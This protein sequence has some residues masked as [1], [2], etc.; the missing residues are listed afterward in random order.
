MPNYDFDCTH[1]ESTVEKNVPIEMREAQFCEECGNPLIRHWSFKG[2]V[3][4]PTK[5]GGHS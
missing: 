5:N 3:W 2:S 4:S 1:C